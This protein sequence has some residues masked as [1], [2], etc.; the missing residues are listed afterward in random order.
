M[1]PIADERK[2]KMKKR[3]PRA[4][5]FGSAVALSLMA[6]G[7][8]SAQAEVGAHWNVNGSAI[9]ESLVNKGVVPETTLENSH[10][11]LLGHAL[12]KELNIL[13]TSMRLE[14]TRFRLE[15]SS[16]AKMRFAGC[17]I[18]TNGGEVLPACEPRNIIGGVEERGVILT[19]LLD[20]LIILHEGPESYDRFEPAEGA[21]LVS[22]LTTI[23]CGFGESIPVL[24]RLIVKDSQL[25]GRV[26]KTTHLV[27]EGPLTQLWVISKTE[28][29][30]AHLDGTA[31][32]FLTGEHAGLKWSG[33]PA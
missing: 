12:G 15:G 8:T 28:E 27:E 26:E 14:E 24:G 33:T 19:N 2:M 1:K 5:A 11:V 7:P 22:V 3:G 9:S 29:H 18:T 6:F 32:V 31:E 20:D 17:R 16:V 21:R 10:G 23:S 30:L 25:E 13:C 4:A